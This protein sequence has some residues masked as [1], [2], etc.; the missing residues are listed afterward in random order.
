[1]LPAVEA[2]FLSA[3]GSVLPAGTSLTAGPSAGPSA[4]AV[5]LV[6]VIASRL[7]LLP[8][9]GDERAG[10]RN[11]A[12]L[13]LTHSFP[14]DGAARDFLVPEDVVGD[15]VEVESPPG[16]PLKRGDDYLVEGRGIR[17]YRPPARADVAVLARVRG[18][19]RR[20]YEQVEPCR[21][22]LAVRVWANERGRA[23]DLAAASLAA[24][25]VAAEDLGN[26]DGGF[27]SQ[28]AVRLRLLRAAA[29]MTA[30]ARSVDTLEGALFH[31][32]DIELILRGDLEQIV[33][34]GEPA[35]EGVIREVRR[36]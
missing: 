27:T 3:L 11:P 6:E 22:D 2:H 19:R 28:P 4:G 26:V 8:A 20:G 25:L 29:A 10:A 36:A 12:F 33:T 23:D 32:A 31:R 17:F 24:V 5:A 30:L 35:L 16:R 34:L 9:A 14:S 7:S 18:E 15:V 1:M 21:I 13:V